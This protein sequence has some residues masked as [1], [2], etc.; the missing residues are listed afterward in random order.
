MS[1]EQPLRAQ[2]NAATRQ[3]HTTLNKLIT[4][5]L[6]LC[7]PPYANNTDLY[8]RGLLHFA[9]I[10]LNIESLYLDLTAND[11]VSPRLADLLA[12]PWVSVSSYSNPGFE[13]KEDD[14]EEDKD[15]EDENGKNA[16]G[17]ANK[18][19]PFPTPREEVIEALKTLIPPA[20]L[21]TLRLRSDLTFL[22]GQNEIDL[23][24]SLSYY[25]SPTVQ[26]WCAHIRKSLKQR[27]HLLV[28]YFWVMYMAVFSGGKWIRARLAEP[29]NAFWLP[30][31]G[32]DKEQALELPLSFWH[33]DGDDSGVN[34]KEDFKAHL[35]EVESVWTEQEQVEI[36]AESRKIFDWC[37]KLVEELDEICADLPS[38]HLSQDGG[39]SVELSEAADED[40]RGDNADESGVLGQSFE[41]VE[42]EELGEEELEEAQEQ[43]E[44]EPGDMIVEKP[45]VDVTKW[46]AGFVD[47]DLV[48]GLGLLLWW[49]VWYVAVAGREMA[50]RVA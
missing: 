50:L 5:R 44:A 43:D 40:D 11:S 16:A 24:V 6:P 9:H 49:V 18:R 12:D 4:S 37:E 35:T 31:G 42:D 25:P 23:S 38:Q 28:A 8:T 48:V 39:E 26:A 47:R 29:G 20:L 2:I 13:T 3:Q 19:T 45:A 21:R 46:H 32:E 22:T 17:V 36:V 34:I 33:Y 7:L 15:E 1:T 27:P 41:A 14:S 10:Y 30:D